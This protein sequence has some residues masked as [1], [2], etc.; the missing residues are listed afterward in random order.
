MDSG[1]LEFVISYEEQLLGRYSSAQFTQKQTLPRREFTL[2]Y[3]D[4]YD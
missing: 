3:K 4:D 1:V 2:N